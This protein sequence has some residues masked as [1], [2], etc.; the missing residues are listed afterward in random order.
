MTIG[1]IEDLFD[2]MGYT[3]V[4]SNLQEFLFF[5]RRENHGINVIYLIDYRQG[6]YIAQDQY[7][8]MKNKITDFFREKGE[9]EVHILSLVFGADLQKARVLSVEDSFCWIVEAFLTDL[10]FMRIR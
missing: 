2:S 3:K 8:H 4:V 9:K 6:L 10:S 7:A 5:Y 1:Q